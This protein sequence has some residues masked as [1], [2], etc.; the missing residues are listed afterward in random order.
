[1]ESR[2]H[3]IPFVYLK[4]THTCTCRED[5]D[6]GDRSNTPLQRGVTPPPVVCA[7]PKRSKE[8]MLADELEH[9]LRSQLEMSLSEI[10][11]ED[12]Y[13]HFLQ[14]KELQKFR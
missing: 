5:T 11:P 13:A 1:M 6:S 2:A 12:T 8:S 14:Q 3:P 7:S 9:N 4:H 10:Q